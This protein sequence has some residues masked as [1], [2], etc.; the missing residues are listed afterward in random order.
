[1]FILFH[2]QEK[3]VAKEMV[4]VLLRLWEGMRGDKSGVC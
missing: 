3:V 4:V 1:M 2:G